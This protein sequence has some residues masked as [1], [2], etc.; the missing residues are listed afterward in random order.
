MQIIEKIV[1]ILFPF[2]V[3]SWRKRRRE[4]FIMNNS[5][6]LVVMAADLAADSGA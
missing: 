5:P 6:T 2:L 4:V 1:Q 3:L